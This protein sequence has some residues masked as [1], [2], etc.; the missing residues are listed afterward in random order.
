[1]VSGFQ[2]G[3]RYARSG[4]GVRAESANPSLT[5]GPR[6]GA[7]MRIAWLPIVAKRMRWDVGTESISVRVHGSRG[8][9]PAFR[10]A[11]FPALTAAFFLM[12]LDRYVGTNFFTNDLGGAPMMYWNMV[13]IWG[14]PEVYVLVLPAFGIFSEVVSAFSTKSL[15]G[16]TSLVIATMAI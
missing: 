11:I 5:V 15:Y 2:S 1:M 9:L 4:V 7:L 16:Y 10:I 3:G 6:M 14:H 13:W 8:S 12:I